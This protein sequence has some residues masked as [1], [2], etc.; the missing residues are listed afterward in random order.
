MEPCDI[1]AAKD[2]KKKKKQ[3]HIHQSIAAN[4]RRE[5]HGCQYG[6]NPIKAVALCTSKHREIF[7]NV[8][9]QSST[10]PANNRRVWHSKERR[11]KNAEVCL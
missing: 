11:Y 9:C 6:R 5:H 4:Q 7:L 10:K 8:I 3:M 1:E 2:C